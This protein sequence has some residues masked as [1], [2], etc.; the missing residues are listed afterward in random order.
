MLPPKQAPG[1]GPVPSEQLQR[2]VEE[3]DL[4]GL[5]E[6]LSAGAPSTEELEEL[7]ELAA[8]KNRLA[9]IGALLQAGAPVTWGVLHDTAAGGRAEALALLLP[10][11][12]PKA[13]DF[14]WLLYMAASR[15]SAKA[16]QVLLN[17]GA[18][19]DVP[20]LEVATRGARSKP[21]QLLLQ[22]A[23][24][25]DVVRS[26]AA[27]LLCTAAANG[28]SMEV[29]LLLWAGADVNRQSANGWT[30]LMV[31]ASSGQEAIVQ[32][33]LEAGADVNQQ[34]ADSSTALMEAARYGH[35]G[36]VAQ[37][38]QAGADVNHQGA[39]GS[40]ALL[41]AV[42][43]PHHRLKAERVVQVLLAAGA[44][45]AAVDLQ[46]RTALQLALE[47]RY[48][49]IQILVT[50]LRMLLA[51]GADGV[52]LVAAFNRRLHGSAERGDVDAMLE[53]A[54]LT[55][56]PELQQTGIDINARDSA[57]RHCLHLLAAYTAQ[58][59][60]TSYYPA[61]QRVMHAPSELR[62]LLDAGVSVAAGSA[63]HPTPLDAILSGDIPKVLLRRWP[64]NMRS[65]VAAEIIRQGWQEA[66]TASSAAACTS[67]R[68]R[69]ICIRR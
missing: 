23:G 12:E 16:I 39:N 67:K 24:A 2:A 34:R 52:S 50:V 11:A 62:R 13:V 56:V 36:T 18:M 45:M 1:N 33:L 49:D 35:E 5:E 10:A 66:K 65:S 17:A 22:A 57:G 25:A 68:Q 44:S 69:C 51:A 9:C 48:A 43:D 64:T 3:G 8:K 4:A 63:T 42:T 29:E 19:V 58:D 54:N 46:G 26:S 21:L 38:L 41:E 6:A 27:D 20:A 59:M 61:M 15:G 28:R 32:L 30:A 55:R 53:L 47:S 37:L 7:L 60:R 40:T 14:G 31:A